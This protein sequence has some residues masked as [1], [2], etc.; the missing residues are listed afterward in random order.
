MTR[1]E[2]IEKIKGLNDEQL[3]DNYIGLMENYLNLNIRVKQVELDRDN[4]FIT[5][6]EVRNEFEERGKNKE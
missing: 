2:L 4:M 3:K 5:L 6:M 1:E